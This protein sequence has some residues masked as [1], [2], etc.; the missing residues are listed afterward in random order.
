MPGLF[1]ALTNDAARAAGI[2]EAFYAPLE[3]TAG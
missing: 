3:Q 2:V 1:V